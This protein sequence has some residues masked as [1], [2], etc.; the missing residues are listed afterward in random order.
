MMRIM[1]KDNEMCGHCK[2][3]DHS[4]GESHFY[5]CKVTD[6]TITYT[7]GACDKFEPGAIIRLKERA[8]KLK[9][10]EVEIDTR[11]PIEL[12]KK[13]TLKG[14]EFQWI[15]QLAQEMYL[16]RKMA[17]EFSGEYSA[18]DDFLGML[19]GR[20]H[21]ANFHAGSSST[22]WILTRIDNNKKTEWFKDES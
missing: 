11:V 6:R 1:N 19:L 16:Q 3:Q 4:T 12:E 9:M 2:N 15:I 8:E 7:S 13:I 18:L 14:H 20:F 5:G 10:K 21:S 17:G 22:T